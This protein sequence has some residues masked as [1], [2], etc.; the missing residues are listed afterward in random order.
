MKIAKKIFRIFVYKYIEKFYMEIIT[1]YNIKNNYL[2]PFRLN[3]QEKTVLIP[4][5]KGKDFLFNQ[6]NSN[7]NRAIF[8]L[9]STNLFSFNEIK[10]L[11][12]AAKEKVK[13]IKIIESEYG[14]TISN[15]FIDKLQYQC[16]EFFVGTN[17]NYDESV[18]D[19]ESYFKQ[20][21]IY[22]ENE[23]VTLAT[24]FANINNGRYTDFWR[25]NPEKLL[26]FI[27]NT[28]FLPSQLK[29][30]NPET[31]DAVISSF[32]KVFEDK[33]KTNIINSIIKYSHD[34]YAQ[35]IN[36]L[37][38]INKVLNDIIIKLENNQI[39]RA[40]Y[41]NQISKL[42]S[43]VK[44]INITKD[45]GYDVKKCME[46]WLKHL[47]EEISISPK[48][49]SYLKTFVQEPVNGF[50]N[51][52]EIELITNYLKKVYLTA[53]HKDSKIPLWRDESLS[54]F[55]SLEINGDIIS[56]LMR[57][58][59][60]NLSSRAKILNYFNNSK[61]VIERNSFLS[62]ALKPHEFMKKDIKW[63]L[64]LCDG[65]KY[66]YVEPLKCFSDG[67]EAEL[68]IH[69]CKLKIT[70]AEYNDEKWILDADI[71]PNNKF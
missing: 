11:I 34:G 52:K 58:A 30:F 47:P 15:K 25:K 13:N 54:F 22:S 38:Q 37:L 63:N 40:D 10:E 19:F 26:L 36:F 16:D 33:D 65:V 35:K 67:S 24:E 62:T 14:K 12:A 49:I 56:N 18:Y 51:Y 46:N 4:A 28:K 8:N 5:F 2:S 39:T 20:Y 32:I 68:L 42:K 60:N 61:P 57:D 64:T 29:N 27:N 17:P 23:K 53:T 71:L 45:I 70:Q 6:I 48:L 21:K 66:L 31:W 7:I 43:L 55:D 3:K 1:N 69:P 59:R 50:S 41:Q 9:K 44:N